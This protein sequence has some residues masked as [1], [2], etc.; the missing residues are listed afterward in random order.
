MRNSIIRVKNKSNNFTILSNELLK[1]SDVS[2]RAKGLYCYLMSLPDDW[3]ISKGEVYTHFTDGKYSMNAAFRELEG[4]GYILKKQVRNDR[5]HFNGW[6]YTVF[7]SIQQNNGKSDKDE[8]IPEIDFSDSRESPHSANQQLLITDILQKTKETKEVYIRI[9]D[10][11][12]AMP[13]L[14]SHTEKIFGKHF[15][16]SHR[17]EADAYGI[18]TVLKAIENYNAV[19]ASPDHYFTHKW[20]LW[21][22]IKRGL[23][24]FIDAMHPLENYRNHQVES[25]TEPIYH[26]VV[27]WRN[28]A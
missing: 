16:K 6:H 3:E 18:D 4:L 26:A 27:D 7:E 15:G 24:K 20:T 11:W 21:D 17:E 12:N 14:P 19:L 10:H 25:S 22:F 28:E 9:L 13:A 5:N 8:G 23:S 2:A 1:R